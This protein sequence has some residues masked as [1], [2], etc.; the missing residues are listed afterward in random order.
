V[1]EKVTGICGGGGIL[2]GVDP[3][4]FVWNQWLV[5]SAADLRGW[6]QIRKTGFSSTWYL[7]PISVEHGRG[8]GLGT[9][10]GVLLRGLGIEFFGWREHRFGHGWTRIRRD[11]RGGL[12]SGELLPLTLRGPGELLRGLGLVGAV[13]DL[14]RCSRRVGALVMNSGTRPGSLPARNDG[15]W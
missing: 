9:E 11:L 6:S 12:G 10:W 4:G 13:A 5:G 8:D 14:E 7:L 15:R 2:E 1:V 3:E